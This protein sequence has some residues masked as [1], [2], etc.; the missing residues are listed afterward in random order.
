MKQMKHWQDPANVL[1]GVWLI[2]SPWALGFQSERNAMMNAVIVGVLLI[3]AA[4]GAIF[5][6]R[7]WEE[8]SETAL[9]L[10]LVI[11]PWVIGFAALET[12]KI[13][14][15]ASGLIVVVL[16]LWVLMTDKDYAGWLG[17]KTAQ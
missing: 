16:A 2:L 15:V 6:P 10:W 5:V 3:A 11:S 4:L 13:S 7:A 1:M 9:G 12:A 17:D 8:W 14:T